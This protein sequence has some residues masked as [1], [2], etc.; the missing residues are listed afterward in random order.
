[1]DVDTVLMLAGHSPVERWADARTTP[2][3]RAL[4]LHVQGASGDVGIGDR[5][6][7]RHRQQ[8]LLQFRHVLV[9]HEVS[10]TGVP[11]G[12]DANQYP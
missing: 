8:L 3:R 6:G 4:A 7:V 2:S 1:M 9:Q 5:L 10:L 12:Y 11:A